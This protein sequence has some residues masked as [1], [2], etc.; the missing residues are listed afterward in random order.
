M[1]FLS[2]L[3]VLFRALSSVLLSIVSSAP[4]VLALIVA[5]TSSHLHSPLTLYLRTV[6]SHLRCFREVTLLM[7][8]S[9]FPDLDEASVEAD[10][11][12]TRFMV[13]YSMMRDVLC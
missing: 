13:F 9:I 4:V 8:T 10:R 3:E 2:A 12:L 11:T 5:V 1:C 6:A 7:T